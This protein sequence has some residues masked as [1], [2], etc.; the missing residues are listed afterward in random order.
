MHPPWLFGGV[1]RPLNVYPSS[2]SVNLASDLD[3]S[4]GNIFGGFGGTISEGEM[5]KKVMCTGPHVARISV[6]LHS[7]TSAF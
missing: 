5:H 4:G 2:E 3:D 6:T 7:F 1:E